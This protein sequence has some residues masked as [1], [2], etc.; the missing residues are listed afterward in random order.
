MN[1]RIQAGWSGQARADTIWPSTTAALSTYSAP[2]AVTSGA[3]AGYAAVRR[4]VS[5]PAA[6]STCGAWHSWAT[7]WSVPMKWRTIRCTSGSLRM[8]SGA[9]PPGMTSATYCAGS[10]SANATS[11][12]QV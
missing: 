12:G 6:A 3:S 1:S 4:P 8:Y 9:R 10:T 7:G 2:A 5:V 11:A